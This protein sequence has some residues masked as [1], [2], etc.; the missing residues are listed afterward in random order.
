MNKIQVTGRDILVFHWTV[1]NSIKLANPTFVR[2]L[3]SDNFPVHNSFCAPRP[4]PTRYLQED[5]QKE[6]R[7]SFLEAVTLKSLQVSNG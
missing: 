7:H 1:K 6:R 4:K 5:S 2:K 3:R